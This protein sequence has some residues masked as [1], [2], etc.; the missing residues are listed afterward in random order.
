MNKRLVEGERA[1]SADH[2]AAEVAEPSHAAL[3]DPAPSV[4]AQG[5]AI[6]Q[7]TRSSVLAVRR[8]HS[9]RFLTRPTTP[10][11]PTYADRRH[12]RERAGRRAV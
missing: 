8:D 7:R 2:Q 4:T 3:D 10:L 11:P 12:C 5:A 1:V 9:L 6:L